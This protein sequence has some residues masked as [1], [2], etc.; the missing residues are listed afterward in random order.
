[1]ALQVE[2][3]VNAVRRQVAAR[4]KDRAP[5]RSIVISRTYGASREDLWDAMTNPER[6]PKWFL[7]VTGDLRSGGNFQLEGNAGGQILQCQAPTRLDI[8]WEWAGNISWVNVDLVDS[9]AVG[10][11]LR[12][13]HMEVVQEPDEFWQQFGPGGGGVG[14]D[15]ALLGLDQHFATGET[16]TPENAAVWLASD[17]GR[18]FVDLSSRAWCEASVAFGTDRETADAAATRTAAFYKGED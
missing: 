17:E 6:I 10:T 15:M 12:L 14:W 4:E 16:I 11:L 8:T 13:E 1:M 3:L 18:A 9:A 7:P 2:R 5:A